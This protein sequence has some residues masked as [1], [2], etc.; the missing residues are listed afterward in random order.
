MTEKEK[1][2]LAIACGYPAERYTDKVKEGVK[3][4][5]PH[6]EEE[7]A[8]ARKMIKR[9]FD[10]VVQLHGQEVADEVIAEFKEYNEHVEKIKAEAKAELG[11]G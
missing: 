7:V 10:L 4:K 5:Y 11:I 9:V 6:L 1:D 2:K 3:E 8:I